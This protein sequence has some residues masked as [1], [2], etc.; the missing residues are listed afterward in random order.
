MN[1]S[2][3]DQLL[4]AG[5]ISQQQANDA[6][7]EQ[8]RQARRPARPAPSRQP[9]AP[10]P[11]HPAKP[12]RDPAA[13]RRQQEKAE[14]KARLAQL[15]RVIEGHRLPLPEG[16]ES[17]HFVDGAKIR[18]IPV[19]APLRARLGLGEL[20]VVRHAGRYSVLPDAVARSLREQDPQLFV[21]SGGTAASA[22]SDAA[23]AKFAVP[24][25]LI[26]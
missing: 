15:Q 4:Q 1:T 20:V 22:E 24:D 21:A 13:M 2:L 19:D 16:G 25:D 6:E 18:H 17:Y 23:Y 10:P 5:L 11:A 26:W 9:V 14:R 8:Q 12:A 3:R 7:R